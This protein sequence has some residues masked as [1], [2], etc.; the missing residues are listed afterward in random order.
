MTAIPLTRTESSQ[1][2]YNRR[3]LRINGLHVGVRHVTAFSLLLSFLEEREEKECREKCRHCRHQLIPGIWGSSRLT[4]RKQVEGLWR[5]A[6]ASGG[7][8]QD[9]VLRWAR[10]KSEVEQMGGSRPHDSAEGREH[11]G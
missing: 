5:E 6:S 2:P 3:H 10:W 9:A 1:M 7:K 11:H 8:G 4:G